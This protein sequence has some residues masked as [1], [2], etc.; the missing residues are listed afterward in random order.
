MNKIKLLYD[1]ARTMKNREKL[2]GI[3]QLS[4]QK[5]EEEIFTL[6]NEFAKNNTGK[7]KTTVS[8]EL[9]L[10]GS[11]VT[12]ESTTE[13]D[14][15]GCCGHGP[16]MMRSLF[17]KHHS[18]HCCGVRSFFGRL[19][20]ALGLLN[21]I[22][23]EEKENGAARLSVNLDELPEEMRASLLDKMQHKAAHCSHHGLLTT[24]R[25]LEALHGQVNVEVDKDRKIDKITLE[26]DGVVRSVESELH[27]LT[28]S[29]E[30]QFA[31]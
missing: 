9:N 25:Q 18:E 6:R 11:H 12:R 31:W 10:D 4:V 14:L 16:G 23:A 27:A 21:S 13:F 1:V 15:P 3:L 30:V 22:A 7:A 17:H 24:C 2:G 19:S 26:L 28:A 20:F 5:D 8:A 29:G